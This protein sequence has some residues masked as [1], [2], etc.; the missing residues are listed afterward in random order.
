MAVLFAP[1]TTVAS[2]RLAAMSMSRR[3]AT[4]EIGQRRLATQAKP[5]YI[6]RMKHSPA[7][8]E[9]VDDAKS[10]VKEIAIDDAR[11]RLADNSDAVL[12]DV[13]EESEWSK[14]HAKDAQYLG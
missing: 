3:L 12:L 4:R 2:T 7:F 13:R 9:L 8:L 14:S 11:E 5:R 1:H 6:S 10:R